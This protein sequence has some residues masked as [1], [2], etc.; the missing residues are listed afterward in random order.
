M[1]DESQAVW[2]HCKS[3]RLV[4]AS[5]KKEPIYLTKLEASVM[6]ALISSYG[7]SISTSKLVEHVY[8]DPDEAPLDPDGCIKVKIFHLKKKG[9]PIHSV[10]WRGGYG[11]GPEMPDFE[12]GLYEM[13]DGNVLYLQRIVREPTFHFFDPQTS[14][15]I[16]V[17]LS[18]RRLKGM[19]RKNAS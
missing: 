19:K 15:E 16:C 10:G 13:E 2:W 1:R 12:L 11:L 18:S 9:I 5:T 14:K 7:K 17:P 6:D 4:K 8:P 3:R